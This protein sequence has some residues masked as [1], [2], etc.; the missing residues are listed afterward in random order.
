MISFCSPSRGSTNPSSS[1]SCSSSEKRLSSRTPPP[2]LTTEA[3][4]RP[5]P[6]PII[7]Y[8]SH[9]EKKLSPSGKHLVRQLSD[10]GFPKDRCARAIL[11]LGDNEKDVVDQLLLIQKMED[12]GQKAASVQLALGVLKPGKDFLKELDR[13]L[14]LFDQLSALGFPSEKIG[15]ALVAAGHDRDKALDILLMM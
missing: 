9:W 3:I 4:S 8:E 6:K 2:R 14:T 5:A 13:H 10:M 15:P 11:R 12:L 7:N 1:T